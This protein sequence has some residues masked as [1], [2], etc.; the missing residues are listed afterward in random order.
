MCNKIIEY[1]C[2]VI[3]HIAYKPS[4]I[5]ELHKTCHSKL[6]HTKREYRKIESPD[7][8]QL[9]F[10]HEKRQETKE[11]LY[12]SMAK[13]EYAEWVRLKLSREIK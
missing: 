11:F 9:K 1:N 3:H 4:K 5:I 8:E 6:H 13:Q 2:G 10:L 12:E 7:Y